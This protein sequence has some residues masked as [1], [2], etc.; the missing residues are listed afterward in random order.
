MN[1]KKKNIPSV[2]I[3]RLSIYHRCLE[4]ILETQNEE[5]LK[6]VSSFKI[7]EMTGINSAQI[8]KDLAY[9][10][11]FG[12]R[13]LG[14]P[15]ID[16]SRELKKILGLDKEWSIIIAGAGNLGKAL[17]K[18]KGFQKR[19]FII[20]GIFDNSPIKIG[21]RLGHIF[22]YNIKEIEKFIQTEKISIGIIVVPAD[23]AQEVA[24]KMVAGGIKAILNFAPVHIT[25]PPEIKIHN[26]DL[27]IEFEGLT[28][29]L[30]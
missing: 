7:E 19:G 12:K 1:L 8:R 29:Y 30:S 14:Y 20:K 18:Y 15:V 10:G 6:I 5:Y 17:V 4:K 3:N 26:V 11:E 23:S 27:S 9:F 21:K 2:T 22:I 28:Y 16:L 25:L 24:D 13:G